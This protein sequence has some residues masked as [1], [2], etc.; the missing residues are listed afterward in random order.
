MKVSEE[1]RAV[2]MDVRA[3]RSLILKVKALARKTGKTFSQLVR[4]GMEMVL[5]E[6]NDKDNS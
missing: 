1:E 3:P 6:H 2:K 4:E 5:G